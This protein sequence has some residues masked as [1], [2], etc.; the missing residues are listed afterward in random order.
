MKLALDE[1]E[2]RWKYGLY[3]F[4]SIAG[5][6]KATKMVG[7]YVGRLTLKNVK[8][9]SSVEVLPLVVAVEITLEVSN[10]TNGKQT[11][12]NRKK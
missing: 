8:T 5:F 9:I 11:K 4:L 10:G 3:C 1:T 6:S 12:E 2:Q 7:I